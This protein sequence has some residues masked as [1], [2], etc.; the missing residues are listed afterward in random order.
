MRKAYTTGGLLIAL[1]IIGSSTAQA[2][3]PVIDVAAIAKLVDQIDKMK[4]QINKLEAARNKLYQTYDHHIWNAKQLFNKHRWTA[5]IE[6]WK[7]PGY[8]NVSGK[9][10]PWYDATMKSSKSADAIISVL[11][12]TPDIISRNRHFGS[13][14]IEEAKR[15][16]FGFMEIMEG[17][18]VNAMAA[19]A[20]V[21]TVQNA[22]VQ[23]IGQLEAQSMS[24]D[25]DENTAAALANKQLSA[26][27]VLIRQLQDDQKLKVTQTELMLQ[28]AML[29]RSIMSEAVQREMDFVA[30]HRE[31]TKQLFS[32]TT[33]ALSNYKGF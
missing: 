20:D 21:R 12:R 19:L 25:K 11:G 2:Q 18:H 29:E 7:Y 33:D 5:A 27:M 4:D 26:T 16:A 22:R 14:D 23:A 13:A 28:R 17:T 3:W 30:G 1:A 31:T 24:D 6:S 9:T 8:A 15:R 32:G 10:Q